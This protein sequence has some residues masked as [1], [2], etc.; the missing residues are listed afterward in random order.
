MRDKIMKTNDL[1]LILGP[2]C[3]ATAG[4][5]TAGGRGSGRVWISWLGSLGPTARQVL[6][7]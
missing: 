4:F 3:E 1:S 5:V 6:G 7:L 2:T